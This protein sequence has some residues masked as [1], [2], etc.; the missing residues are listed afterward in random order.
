MPRAF[1]TSTAT[2]LSLGLGL[3]ATQY[4]SF[5]RWLPLDTAG[6]LILAALPLIALSTAIG[7]YLAA[8]PELG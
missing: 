3:A 4:A 2:A 1:T 8:H 7:R 6:R 5:L